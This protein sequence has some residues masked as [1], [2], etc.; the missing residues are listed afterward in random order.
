[1]V[2]NVTERLNREL[3]GYPSI[4]NALTVIGGCEI[5]GRETKSAALGEISEHLVARMVGGT[6]CRNGNK[7]FDIVDETGSKIE[8]K[9]RLPGEWG[10]TLQFNFRKHSISA[11]EVFC[12][13]WK[14]EDTHFSIAEAYKVHITDLLTRWGT[15]KQTK[16]FARTSL[17]K[18]RKVCRNF[19]VLS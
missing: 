2:E 15:P 14:N 13:C 6:R 8:V 18:L 16:F 19:E 12:I 17:G 5:F 10:D 7:G 1:M 9:S 3:A 11:N 4:Q